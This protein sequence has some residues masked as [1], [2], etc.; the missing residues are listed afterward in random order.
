MIWSIVKVYTISNVI[1]ELQYLLKRLCLSRCWHIMEDRS[2]KDRMRHAIIRHVTLLTWSVLSYQ[3]VETSIS[4]LC[5]I[6]SDFC[7]AHQ[8]MWLQFESM[9]I[10]LVTYKSRNMRVDIIVTTNV[11]WISYHFHCSM[12]PE[13]Q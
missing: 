8:S 9:N 12:L 13:F 10:Q 2:I 5:N 7:C 11:P 4:S 1:S 3:P 6:I